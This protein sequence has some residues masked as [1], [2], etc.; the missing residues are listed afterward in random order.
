VPPE[1]PTDEGSLYSVVEL[2]PQHR[3]RWLVT[4]QRSAHL[5]DLDTRTYERVPGPDSK[6]FAHDQRLLRLSRVE[7]WP[8]VAGTFFIWLDDPEEPEVI[9]H[10]RQSS[11]IRTIC[12]LPAEEESG[13]V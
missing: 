3:G 1:P 8:V 4:T 2:T 6:A 5:F 11:W 10:W 9:E 7:R 12:R 13:R